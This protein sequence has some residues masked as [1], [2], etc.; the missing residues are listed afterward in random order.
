MKNYSRRLFSLLVLFTAMGILIF[1]SQSAD[2]ARTGIELSLNAVI[3]S[4]FPFMVISCVMI[5]SGIL[6]SFSKALQPLMK[7]FNLNKSCA[8]TVVLGLI[9][10][11][12]MGTKSAVSLYQNKLCSK[13]EGERLLTFCNNT[14]PAF[15][16]ITVGV[17][18]YKSLTIGIMLLSAQ[19][20]S[21]MLTGIVFGR[22]WKPKEKLLNKSYTQTAFQNIP[23][24]FIDAIKASSLSIIYICAFVV[25]FCV[26]INLLECCYI[27]NFLSELLHFAGLG[28]FLEK[29]N[30][31]QLI[32]G[33]FEITAG[34]KK[35]SAGAIPLAVTG[36]I[37]GWAGISVHCQ[38]ITFLKESPFSAKPY[39]LGKL[40]QSIS[41]FFITYILALLFPI[42]KQVFLNFKNENF[43]YSTTKI[44]NIFFVICLFF[45]LFYKIIIFIK[46]RYLLYKKNDV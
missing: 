14:S 23:L 16:L 21:S 45:V 10:G 41:S 9:S 37:L 2:S 13:T 38:I 26:F 43:F 34:V 18:I 29:E 24:S 20:L 4:I 6:N 46:K 3:P 44:L 36:S 12:P 15:I 33:F 17:G 42:E 35:S 19:I 39:I 5:N 40:F 28:I 22:F 27:I 25:F 30:I 8:G 7:L 1:P 32:I 31:S 11:Y